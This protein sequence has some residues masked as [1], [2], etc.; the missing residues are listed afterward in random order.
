MVEVRPCP[1]SNYQNPLL[2]YVGFTKGTTNSFLYDGEYL[3]D[4][5][6]VIVVSAK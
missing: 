6:D 3:A 5:Q 4:T 1:H 2:I